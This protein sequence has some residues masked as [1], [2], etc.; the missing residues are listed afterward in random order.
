MQTQWSFKL[1]ANIF[2]LIYSQKQTQWAHAY[3]NGSGKRL[4]IEV[5]E[6]Y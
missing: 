5:S 3:G 4:P 1:N 2:V 6:Q